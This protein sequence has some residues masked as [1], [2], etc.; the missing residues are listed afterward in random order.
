MANTFSQLYIQ[1]VF[2]VKHRDSQIQE[3]FRDELEK[4]ICGII[5]NKG[6]KPISIYC[7]PNHAHIFIG[8]NPQ[9]SIS[10]LVRDI[11]AHS[12]A[13][14]NT[15]KLATSRFQWQEG[16]GAFSYSRS[17]VDKVVKYIQDQPNHH[18]NQT[19]KNEYVSFLQR[20][21]INYKEENLFDWL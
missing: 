16:F 9:I 1:L 19:F 6:S 20:F 21:D 12:T 10:D 18:R 3:S 15:K 5:N 4:Y 14:I 17:S 13:F 7:M 8:L 11:K 2:A